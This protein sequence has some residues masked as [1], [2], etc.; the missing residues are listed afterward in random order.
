MDSCCWMRLSRSIKKWS[1]GAPHIWKTRS[2]SQPFSQCHARPSA[3]G[4]S[5]RASSQGYVAMWKV[6]TRKL[7]QKFKPSENAPIG[8]STMQTGRLD[9]SLGIR[10][11]DYVYEY[12]YVYEYVLRIRYTP[13]VY[14]QS[15]WSVHVH[16][17]CGTWPIGFW[18]SKSAPFCILRGI[19]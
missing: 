7:P 10:I 18:P 12:K 16:T 8:M 9:S 13:V 3:P 5:G 11:N 19:R 1:L 6:E 14:S 15:I 4:Q 17:C 2:S